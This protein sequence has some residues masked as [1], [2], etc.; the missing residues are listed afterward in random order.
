MLVRVF[1]FMFKSLYDVE[2]V[3]WVPAHSSEHEIGIKMIRNG[4]KLTAIDR[5]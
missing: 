5:D 2:D 1:N 3:V 4:R